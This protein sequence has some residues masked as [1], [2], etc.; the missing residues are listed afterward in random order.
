M[1][2]RVAAGFPSPAEDYVDAE[3]DL[4]EYLIQHPAATFFLRVSG[5]SM[6]GAGI[7]PGDILI[8]DR[9]LT[10]VPGRVVIAVVNGELT[11]KRL[12]KHLGQLQLAPENPDFP[13][14]PLNPETDFEV[15]GVVTSV[16]HKV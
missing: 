15:W 10:P 13:A 7:H 5:E 8:V 6:T 16:I 14:T 4:N 9:A 3:L 12:K 11:V 1:L 2:S